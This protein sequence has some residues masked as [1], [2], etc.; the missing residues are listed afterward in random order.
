ME[1]VPSVRLPYMCNLWL[2]KCNTC[3]YYDYIFQFFFYIFHFIFKFIL[4]QPWLLHNPLTAGEHHNLCCATMAFWLRSMA[5]NMRKQWHLVVK[6]EYN[7]LFWGPRR[8]DREL[9]VDRR[10]TMHQHVLWSDSLRL[11][12]PLNAWSSTYFIFSCIQ[13]TNIWNIS[14]MLIRMT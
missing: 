3:I 5:S 12:M 7:D 10:V 2:R 11:W 8:A 6:C 4:F 9:P 1:T 13:N 14:L